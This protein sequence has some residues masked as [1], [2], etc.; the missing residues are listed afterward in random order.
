[1]KHAAPEPQVWWH[2]SLVL[3][4]TTIAISQTEKLGPYGGDAIKWPQA[5]AAGGSLIVFPGRCLVGQILPAVP[6]LDR[7][8][9]PPRQPN[10]GSAPSD[11]LAGDVLSRRHACHNGWE[12]RRFSL[13]TLIKTA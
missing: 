3:I 7:P 4:G 13:E 2:Y 1:M 5:Q 12:G 10:P 8:W 11:I 9:R 6:A